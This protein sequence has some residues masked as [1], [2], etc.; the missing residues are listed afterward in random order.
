MTT[1]HV[2]TN[3]RTIP[4]AR[5]IHIAVLAVAMTTLPLAAWEAY[6]RGEGFVP[7]YRNSDGLWALTRNRLERADGEKIVILGSSRALFD[8]NLESWAYET[9]LLPFQLALEGSSPRPLLA[10][11]AKESDFSGLLVM[12]EETLH[13]NPFL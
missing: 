8:M 12:E 6:W 2:A 7:S 5:W 3:Y 13:T 10:H 11:L 9:G 4:A 1:G